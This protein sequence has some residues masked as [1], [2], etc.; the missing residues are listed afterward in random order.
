MTGRIWRLPTVVSSH[1]EA[2]LVIPVLGIN[3]VGIFLEMTT[4]SGP[5][6][7]SVANSAINASVY[8]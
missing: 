7:A 6:V 3:K 8:N 2:G 4:P 5:H 1:P